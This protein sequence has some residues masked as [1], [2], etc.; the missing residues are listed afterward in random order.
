MSFEFEE[1]IR[2]S[3]TDASLTL[4]L[5]ALLDLF[6]DAP[7][8]QAERLGV[9]INRLAEEH[10]AWYLLS[11]NIE[12]L[13][14]PKHGERVVVGT[15]PYYFR[16]ALGKRN[17]YLRSESGEELARADSLWVMMDTEQQKMVNAPEWITSAYALSEPLPMKAF[18]RKILI[19]DGMVPCEPVTVRAEHI[20]FHR[21]VNNGQYIH[22]IQHLLPDRI[23][24]LCVEYRRQTALGEVLVPYVLRDEHGVTISLQNGEPNVN[25]RVDTE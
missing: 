8:L 17:C 22:M 10:L 1:I 9:G 16:G 6:Q 14:M 5:P 23:G 7:T 3:Q 2:Y 19:P 21:H 12:I 4:T 13:R 15:A 25:I 24:R 20:D 18:P 11:W